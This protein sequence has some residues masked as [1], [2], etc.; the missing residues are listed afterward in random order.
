MEK[1][2]FKYHERQDYSGSTKNIE[3]KAIKPQSYET[4]VTS[5]ETALEWLKEEWRVWDCDGGNDDIY[6]VGINNGIETK[7][8]EVK[9]D[10]WANHFWDD[11]GEHHFEVPNYFEVKEITKEESK[12]PN[13]RD[14][15]NISPYNYKLAKK[16]PPD[17]E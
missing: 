10:F 2:I 3:W 15:L 9:H 13:D 6:F 4:Q 12:I 7:Y 16:W 17:D 5:F 14:W 8:Y 1:I 11:S